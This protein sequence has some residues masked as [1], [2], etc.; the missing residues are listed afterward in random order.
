MLKFFTS[1]FLD[2]G[3][4][5]IDFDGKGKFFTYLHGLPAGLRINLP[6]TGWQKEKPNFC[7]MQKEAQ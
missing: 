4:Y 6:E 1:L 5:S 7:Y 2:S 3:I